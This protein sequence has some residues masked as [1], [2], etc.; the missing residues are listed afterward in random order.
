MDVHIVLIEKMKKSRTFKIGGVHPAEN[1]LAKNVALEDFPLPQ[2]ATVFVTQSLG[3]AAVPVVSKGDRVKVGQLLSKADSLICANVHAPISGTITK[4][5]PAANLAGYKQM[6]FT[7]ERE[8][9]DWADEI[10]TSSELK[11][12]IALDKAGIIQRIK[13]CGIVGLGGACFPTHVK[14]MLRPEQKCDF[15]IVNAAECEP[16][17]TTDHRI[18]VEE[19]HKCIV[20]IEAA[21]RAAE[22]KKAFIGI[23]ENKPEAIET[24]KTLV[25]Q[26]PN[27]EVVTLQTKYPQ[28]A[29]KQLID[30]ITE[31][32]VPNGGLPIDVGCIVTN[33]S[34]MYAIY[35]AV[36]KNK[37]LVECHT[38]ISGKHLEHHKNYKIRIG[39]PLKEVLNTVGIPENTGKIISG[40]L[41]M[42]KAIANLDTFF[43]KGM[44]SILFVDE[45]ESQRESAE[46]CIRCG[47]CVSACPMGLEPYLL[48]TLS[49]HQRYDDLERNGILT[50]ME[51][52]CCQFSCPAHLPLLDYV[53]LGKSKVLSIIRN[54]K[55]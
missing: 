30:A 35:E 1:K 18:M 53:R 29:E 15:I 5:E 48:R 33:I 3:A 13:D 24:F 12:E 22:A 43:V 54:R 52:G 8:G 42:G 34:T 39:T 26:Y 36:Q 4:I 2:Q 49:E 37:P 11:T 38:T 6:A 21:I 25:A 47:K 23:E 51:C 9:D 28:G 55:S 45:S 19:S 10:D 46:T 50:C 27:V 31:R 40:G 14:Y 20:G 17:I 32:R 44:S 7:I 41:M 16:Y